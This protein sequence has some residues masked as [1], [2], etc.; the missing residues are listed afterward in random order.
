MEEKNDKKIKELK[1]KIKKDRKEL[2]KLGADLDGL[3]VR[4]KEKDVE[5][6]E[7]KKIMTDN[8]I[9]CKIVKGEVDSKKVYVD[10]NFIGILDI[11]PV[12]EGHTLIIPK[13]HYETL[14]D[15]PNTLGNELVEAIKKVALDL[16]KKGKAEGFNIVQSNYSVAQQEVPHLHFHIIP[17]KKQDGLNYHFGK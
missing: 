9:F 10:D 15:M 5:K 6:L 14:L 8:C 13:K 1:K 3:D 2:K 11:S 7:E 4:D 12:S 17:R 16:I